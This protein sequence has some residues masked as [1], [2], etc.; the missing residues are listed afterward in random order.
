MTTTDCVDLL[1]T[2]TFPNETLEGAAMRGSL[3]TAFPWSPIFKL[4]FEAVLVAVRFPVF[5]PADPG[6]N[7]TVALTLWPADR[8]MGRVT[9]ETLNAELLDVSAETVAL[10]LPLLVRVTVWA[11]D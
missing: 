8:T 2:A 3:L 5:Q 1:P 4:V 9:P 11:S 7:V 6:A 10:V